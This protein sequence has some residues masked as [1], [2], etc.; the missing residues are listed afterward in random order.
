MAGIAWLVHLSSNGPREF[1]R[2]M[3]SG[4]SRNLSVLPH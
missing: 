3:G 4:E 2:E 1:L